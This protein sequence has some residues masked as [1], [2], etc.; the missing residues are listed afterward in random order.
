M[1]HAKTGLILI[2]V[3]LLISCS[4][5]TPPQLY[6]LN[7]I[8][9]C[10]HT[11]EKKFSHLKIGIN[12]VQLPEYIQKP[13]ITLHCSKH[14][15][16]LAENHHWAES[17]KDNI[18]RVL[19]TNLSTLLPGSVIEQTPWYSQLSPSY[20]LQVIISLFETDVHGNN[21]FRAEY[22]IYQEHRVVKNGHLC[23]KKKLPIVT[24]TS[25]VA[26]MNENINRLSREISHSFKTLR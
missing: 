10:N 20:T 8:P 24:P 21:I 26:A 4:R 11:K 2:I 5:S 19:R 22:L 23:Y 18:A 14:Q 16:K 3:S 1:N 7:P 15:V 25:V 9:C 13:E 6:V 12:P 17:L